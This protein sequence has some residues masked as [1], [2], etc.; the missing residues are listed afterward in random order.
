[1]P[2]GNVAQAAKRIAKT[3]PQ[4]GMLSGIG[5]NNVPT[6][7][8]EQDPLIY[9]TDGVKKNPSNGREFPDNFYTTADGQ[10]IFSQ[11]VGR[12]LEGGAGAVGDF[13]E[14]G[15]WK[16]RVVNKSLNGS[17]NPVMMDIPF[18]GIPQSQQERADRIKQAVQQSTSGNVE[19]AVPLFA[20]DKKSAPMP[21][22]V[23]NFFNRLNKGEEDLFYGMDDATKQKVIRGTLAMMDGKSDA[24][25]ETLKNDPDYQLAKWYWVQDKGISN[26]DYTKDAILKR[27]FRNTPH[28][29][30]GMLSGIGT[31]TQNTTTPTR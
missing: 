10:Q 5:M 4:R 7:S 26:D 1:M 24:E 19:G 14:G 27:G 6:G 20:V 31:N 11:D 23:T 15:K 3:V 18:D 28:P 17:Y 22:Q 13:S 29:A 12:Y 16:V 2:A 30:G 9:T 21:S 25:I 8:P